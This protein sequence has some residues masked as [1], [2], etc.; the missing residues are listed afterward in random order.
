MLIN[1]HKIM[2]NIKLLPSDGV[3]VSKSNSD[4]NAWALRNGL[5]KILLYLDQNQTSETTS[6]NMQ[7]EIRKD[8]MSAIDKGAPMYNKG[9]IVGCEKHYMN[10]LT[11]M[12]DSSD[13]RYSNLKYSLPRIHQHLQIT[14]GNLRPSDNSNLRNSVSDKNAWEL[15]RCF[16][17]ILEMENYQGSSSVVRAENIPTTSGQMVP[18]L[19]PNTA[20]VSKLNDGVMGGISNSNW[21]D[22]IF[23]GSVR[24]DNNGGFA[25][26]RL[27]FPNP[28]NVSQFDGFYIKA[29]N[30]LGPQAKNQ[31][32][33]VIM[34]DSL[35][36][37][38][39]ATNFKM[40]FKPLTGDV[41]CLHKITAQSL[42]QP[43][44]FGRPRNDQW[45]CDMK[46]ICEIGIMAIKPGV[47]GDFKLQI[48]EIGVFK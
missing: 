8:I 39:M 36:M 31:E 14:K 34:K 11:S 37:Q 33:C 21:Q 5:D 9:N 18:L 2:K 3:N 10:L 25:S 7:L 1:T 16:D 32:F 30:M 48:E 43:E 24:L 23:S 40:K 44:S 45:R 29:R 41:M 19:D 13:R 26:L 4:K 38:T 46:R 15:R 12:L 17:G 20:G 6:H 27:R 47:I 28:L 22:G 35:C 42:N